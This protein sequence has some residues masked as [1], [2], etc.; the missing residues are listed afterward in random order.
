MAIKRCA[1]TN[2]PQLRQT[3]KHTLNDDATASTASTSPCDPRKLRISN[4]DC[5]QNERISSTLNSRR[6]VA[7]YL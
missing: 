4:L 7:K 2:R 5:T 1:P 6:L 3:V